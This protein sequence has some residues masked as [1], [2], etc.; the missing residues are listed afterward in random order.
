MLDPLIQLAF[1][2]H[3]SPGVFALLLGSGVSRP[4]QI[5][6]GWEIVRDLARKLARLAGEDPEPADP[7]GWYTK[8]HGA[9][10][11][12]SALLSEIAPSQTSRQALLQGYFEPTEDD[13]ANGR[14]VPT[15]AH[16]A[17]GGL[18]RSGHVRVIIT[19]NFD[20]LLEAAL[21]DVG[22]HPVLIATTDAIKG[23]P[24]LQHSPCTVIKVHG[25]YRDTRIR[26]T[27]QELA[28][29]PSAMSELLDRVFDEHGLVVCGWSSEWDTALRDALSRRQSR[30]YPCYWCVKDPLSVLGPAPT[31]FGVGSEPG[32]VDGRLFIAKA[33]TRRA[34]G[35][36]IRCTG[37]R[38]P[39]SA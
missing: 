30:R 6:T 22:I 39:T 5:P 32:S 31:R 24:P 26:N 17:I 37:P 2:I 16:K 38:A 23:A 3:S 34:S 11:S 9:E 15:A 25:D 14:K 7:V 28:A 21:E 18:V 1:G 13:I 33:S 8:A 20:R 35:S 4:A 27:D 19:T 10:P 29:Y 12:Y 36:R